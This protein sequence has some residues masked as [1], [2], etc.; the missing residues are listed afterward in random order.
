MS[1]D[2]VISSEMSEPIKDF[3][4]FLLLFLNDIFM[5][6]EWSNKIQ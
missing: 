2:Y 3:Q 1:D 4:L 5:G 6:N